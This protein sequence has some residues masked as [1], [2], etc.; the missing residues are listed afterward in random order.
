MTTPPFRRRGAGWGIPA[1]LGL[2]GGADTISNGTSGWGPPPASSGGGGNAGGWG[3]APP[4]NASASAAWGNP[5]P[6][7]DAGGVNGGAGASNNAA[8]AGGAN[9][10]GAM[11]APQQQG[12][13]QQQQ[14]GQ[15]QQPNSSSSSTSGPQ[16][17]SST[18][19]NA[20]AQGASSAQPPQ[21][22]ASWA[23]AAGKGLPPASESGNGN[24][25]SS[26]TNKQLEHLNSV[27]EALFSQDGWG[28]DNVKQD[29]AW[30]SGDA[31][32]GA[33]AAS[34][35]PPIW[36]GPPRND[37]TDLWKSTLSGQPPAP[38]PQPSN[39]WGHTPQ[40]PTDFKQWGEEDDSG[41]DPSNT[42]RPDHP[43]G[44][45]NSK[46]LYLIFVHCTFHCI[47]NKYQFS[48]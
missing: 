29:T 22:A 25:N 13:P 47:C 37:G 26:S 27:R 21:G 6:A 11:K 8:A 15:N 38:K 2:K 10:A 18:T 12:Q 23:A 24:G 16:N 48:T 9:N 1:G 20:T 35:E 4:P 43:P 3:A 42:W 34:K 5:N 39:P 46:S 45:Y 40:N 14:Q 17:S 41:G 7:D 33:Q 28:G 31:G 36:G 44:P 19:G 30:D 32:A